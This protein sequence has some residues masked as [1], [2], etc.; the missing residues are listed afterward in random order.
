[1]RRS[2]TH[3][4]QIPVAIV[5]KLALEIH[6]DGLESDIKC[7]ICHKP[8]SLE[9]TKTDEVGHVVHEECYFLKVGIKPDQGS[10]QSCRPRNR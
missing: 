8:V 2:K 6:D 1:M 7:S 4:A 5:K 9:T 10:G 3:F